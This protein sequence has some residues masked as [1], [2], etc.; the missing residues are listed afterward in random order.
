MVN[1]CCIYDSGKR[2]H[3]HTRR[4]TR[5]TLYICGVF[6][7]LSSLCIFVYAH[8][9]PHI[10]TLQCRK[11]PMSQHFQPV[12]T[13]I[14]ATNSD[15]TAIVYPP[16]PK[17]AYPFLK[18]TITQNV[19][20]PNIHAVK[21]NHPIHWKNTGTSVPSSNQSPQPRGGFPALGWSLSPNFFGV[22]VNTHVCRSTLPWAG[23][24]SL[25]C[26]KS[27]PVELE[28]ESFWGDSIF[29]IRL[30]TIRI[31]ALIRSFTPMHTLKVVAS[32]GYLHRCSI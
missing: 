27:F 30:I 14:T 31:P 29:S 7:L 32:W 20:L 21:R 4:Y 17:I 16:T 12:L 2:W 18:A 6:L 1:Y 11:K 3:R 10:A 8:S 26:S 19:K 28:T 23:S 9:S 5:G 24:S 22:D 13:L 25:A 15:A